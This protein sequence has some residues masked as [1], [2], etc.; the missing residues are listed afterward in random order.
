[1]W[2]PFKESLSWSLHNSMGGLGIMTMYQNLPGFWSDGTIHR[3]ALDSRLPRSVPPLPLFC[4]SSLRLKPRNSCCGAVGSA[5]PLE[6][7]RM[8]VRIPS[9]SQWVKDLVLPQLHHRLDGLG[10]PYGQ[11]GQK[12]KKQTKKRLNPKGVSFPLDCELQTVFYSS[13]SL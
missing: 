11:C 4:Y 1:M 10:T 12:R 5:A 9:W 8:Q 2:G 7:P 13:W 3:S 6:C